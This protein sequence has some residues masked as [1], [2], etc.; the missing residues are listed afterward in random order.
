MPIALT[1]RWGRRGHRLPLARAVCEH[2]VGLVFVRPETRRTDPPSAGTFVAIVEDRPLSR[3]PAAFDQAA[4]RALVL[5]VRSVS[6]MCAADDAGPYLE[7]AADAVKGASSLMVETT[8]VHGVAWRSAILA[9]VPT[10][11][12]VLRDE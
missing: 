8:A 4:F 7:A 10:L 2:R 12:V 6:V 1:R 5:S 11:P 9:I 3:G